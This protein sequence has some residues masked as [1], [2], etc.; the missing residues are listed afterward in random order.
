MAERA[1][2]TPLDG[3]WRGALRWLAPAGA[4][5]RLSILIFHRVLAAPD[6][7]QPDEPDVVEFERQM[8]RVQAW[9]NVMPLADAAA[10]LR[11]GRLPER[12]LAITFDDGYA[13]NHDLALPVL[14]RLGL[15]ATF[16]IATAYL[17]GGCMFNDAVTE[18][19]RCAPAGA[20]DLSDLGLGQYQ[21][22]G[23]AQ[24]R[25]AIAGLLAAVK[26]LA[27]PERTA[28]VSALAQRCGAHLPTTLMMTSAQVAA[29]HRAGMTIGAH[30][31]TH[32]ILAQVDLDTARSEIA[33]GRARLESLIGEPVRLFAYPNGRP[34][35][36]YGPEHA[37]LVQALGFDAAVSTAW[38][39]ASREAD[40]FQL[41]RFTP[42]DRTPWR[43]G[44]RLARTLMTPTYAHA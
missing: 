14:R 9:F 36:D 30:T 34:G 8:R 35:R 6:P 5:A 39:T 21:I 26:Y 15:P 20:L 4:R 31:D 40:V 43:Y 42:W 7:L 33:R 22:V 24:R 12:A 19:I 23:D 44:L 37:S 25:A 18:S 29:L 11:A 38:G 41:P 28:K 1:A 13:D 10:A 16:F 32:P 17:D 27:P 2:A 3:L